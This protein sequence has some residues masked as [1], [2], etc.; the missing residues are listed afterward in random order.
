MFRSEKQ[1]C[2]AI[3]LL[4]KSLHM[5]RFWTDKGPTKQACKYLEGSPL[6]SG[7]QIFLRCAFD[8][9]NGDGKVL[10]WQDLLGSLDTPRTELLF[11]LVI[12]VNRGGDAVQK[13]IDTRK[14]ALVCAA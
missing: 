3:Q 4:L 14:A 5:E 11:T 13:W 9:W 8:L 12:A 7:E 10:L 2:E 6:S 1:Q